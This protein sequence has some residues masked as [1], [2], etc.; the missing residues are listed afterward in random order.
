M[1]Y[2]ICTEQKNKQIKISVIQNTTLPA[3]IFTRQYLLQ[4]FQRGKKYACYFS[5]STNNT[6]NF[7]H[8]GHIDIN[9]T[10]QRFKDEVYTLF[11]HK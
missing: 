11:E 4:T 2:R 7:L 5:P 8:E 9:L 10:W 3:R 6:N 1:M